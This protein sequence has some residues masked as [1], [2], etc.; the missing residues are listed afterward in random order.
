MAVNVFKMAMFVVR[1]AVK[2]CA[3]QAWRNNDVYSTVFR[4]IRGR[5]RQG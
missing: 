4:G 3:N 1:A 2:G 5:G